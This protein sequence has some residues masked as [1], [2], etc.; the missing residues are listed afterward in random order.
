MSRNPRLVALIVIFSGVLA[1]LADLVHL[2][3]PLQFAFV[4]WFVAVCPGLAIG[5]LIGLKEPLAWIGLTVP[6][7]LAVVTVLAEAL[8]IAHR[9]S[10]TGLLAGL[11]VA[12]IVSCAIP[13]PLVSGAGPSVEQDLP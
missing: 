8:V 13:A 4:L 11:V 1:L 9:W 3:Q 2:G 7:S 12:T 6:I 10:P 5:R